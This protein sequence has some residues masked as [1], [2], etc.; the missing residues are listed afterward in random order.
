[1]GVLAAALIVGASVF[2]FIH[3]V[4]YGIIMSLVTL[5]SV[6]IVLGLMLKAWPHTPIGK[7]VMIG[8]PNMDELLPQGED[9]DGLQKLVGKKGFARSKMLPS[10]AIRVDGR[11]YD[12]MTDGSAIEKG[13]EIEVSAIRMNKIIVRPITKLPPPVVQTDDEL[14]SKPADSLGLDWDEA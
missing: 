10:G 1:M 14:L 13:T 9:Y 3:D 11:V 2:A 6:P 7:R 12:A 4:R 5:V 8:R